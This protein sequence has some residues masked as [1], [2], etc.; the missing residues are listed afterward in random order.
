MEIVKFLLLKGVDINDAEDCVIGEG[1]TAFMHALIPTDTSSDKNEEI[2]K[3]LLEKSADLSILD[4]N[5]KSALFY[6]I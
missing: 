4:K 1:R 2:V 6:G 5:G 3:H